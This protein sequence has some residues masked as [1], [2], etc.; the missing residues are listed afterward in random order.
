MPMPG[1][2]FDFHARR[3]RPKPPETYES[4]RLAYAGSVPGQ[5]LMK[6]GSQRRVKSRSRRNQWARS[7]RHRDTARTSEPTSPEIGQPRQIAR[8]GV[9]LRAPV[10]RCGGG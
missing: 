5:P 4:P 6:V 1:Q 8:S 9:I 10:G 3:G 7:G 2:P